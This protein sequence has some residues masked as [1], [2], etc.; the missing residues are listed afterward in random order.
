MRIAPYTVANG[1]GILSA[2]GETEAALALLQLHR[3]RMGRRHRARKTFKRYLNS[4]PNHTYTKPY[5]VPYRQ[6]TRRQ[7]ETQQ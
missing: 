3:A 5:N 2:E 6:I 7:H 4:I 1:I